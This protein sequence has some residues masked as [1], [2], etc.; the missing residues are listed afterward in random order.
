MVNHDS[1]YSGFLPEGGSFDAAGEYV[2]D[3]PRCGGR[4]KFYWNPVKARGFCFGGQCQTKVRGVEDYKALFAGSSGVSPLFAKPRDY[5]EDPKPE[6]IDPTASDD[7][8][9]YPEA[10]GFLGGEPPK[11]RGLS[12]E[13][14]WE[15]GIRARGS[16]IRVS[17]DPV[18]RNHPPYVYVRSADG[19]SPWMPERAG[20]RR[21]SYVYGLK[22]WEQ[23]EPYLQVVLFEGIFDVLGTGLYGRALALMG[24]SLSQ[25]LA[26][27]LGEAYPG[28]RAYYWPDPDPAGQ[29]GAVKAS[30]TLAGWGIPCARVDTVGKPELNPKFVPSGEARR[31]LRELGWC[32][33]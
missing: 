33:E 12:R 2:T 32:A 28:L 10:R 30:A 5:R 25:D 17:L 14:V 26:R 29:A 9:D 8:W 22:A 23:V 15:G 20:V 3:C 6:K 11:G 4:R 16:R 18:C 27:Y 24:S 13:V 31:I 7:P 19:S 21:Q 1:R